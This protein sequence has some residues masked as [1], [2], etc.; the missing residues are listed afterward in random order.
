MDYGVYL[1]K[2]IVF[3]H[4]TEEEAKKKQLEFRQLIMAGVKT[5]YNVEDIKIKAHIE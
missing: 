1:D 5:C 2:K 3:D 4:L